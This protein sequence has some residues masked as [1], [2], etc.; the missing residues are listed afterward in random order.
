[1]TAVRIPDKPRSRMQRYRTT[2]EG[3]VPL[4][5]TQASPSGRR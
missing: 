2:E 1:M 5:I 4:A 3:L